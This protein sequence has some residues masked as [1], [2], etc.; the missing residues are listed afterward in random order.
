[1]VTVG[2]MVKEK[3]IL[4]EH[5]VCVWG[6]I[7]DR[8]WSKGR[9]HTL[10]TDTASDSLWVGYPSSSV[11]SSPASDSTGPIQPEVSSYSSQERLPLKFSPGTEPSRDWVR[12][13]CV[14][15]H[16]CTCVCVCVCVCVSKVSLYCFNSTK[17]QRPVSSA[18]FPVPLLHSVP[19]AEL[20]PCRGQWYGWSMELAS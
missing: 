8:S 15:M 9:E 12:N 17:L 1:M 16:S 18:S 14:C 5:G 13:D 10:P 11:F 4:P 3:A 7:C 19:G 2:W 20:C 6:C